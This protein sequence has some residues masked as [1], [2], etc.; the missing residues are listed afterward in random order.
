MQRHVDPPPRMQQRREKRTRPRLGD[1]HR[2]IPRPR[3]D[4]LRPGAVA[5][6]ETP[7]AALV[8][9]GTDMGLGLGVD[10]RLQDRVQQTAHQLTLIGAAQHL[11]QLE[12]GR[13]V[14][15]H[16]VYLFREFLGRF[17]QSLT[18]WP[19]TPGTDTRSPDPKDPSYTTSGD[20]ILDQ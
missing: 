1:L 17:S 3:R 15:G 19:P 20:V 10:Q 16:R 8:Q 12:Q 11:G 9:A 13:L 2:Q 7:V 14:Q 5:L 4:H 18:R 6:S